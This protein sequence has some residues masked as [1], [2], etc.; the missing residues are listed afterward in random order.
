M[1]DPPF[2]RL[3]AQIRDI[4]PDLARLILT[5]VHE[6]LGRLTVQIPEELTVNLPGSADWRMYNPTAVF[7]QVMRL[8]TSRYRSDG[9][10][11][12]NREERAIGRGYRLGWGSLQ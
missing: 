5:H 3:I 4:G 12:I 8:P 9:A 11:S 7:W 2:L 10:Y 6:N 1:A